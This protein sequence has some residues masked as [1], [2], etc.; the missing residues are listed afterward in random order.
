MKFGQVVKYIEIFFSK[1][2]T[3]HLVEKLVLDSILENPN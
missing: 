3:Q 1:K 2:H